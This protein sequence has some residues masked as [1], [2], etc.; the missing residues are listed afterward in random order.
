MG[1]RSETP[2]ANPAAIPARQ[3]VQPPATPEARSIGTQERFERSV[4]VTDDGPMIVDLFGSSFGPL[5]KEHWIVEQLT[6]IATLQRPIGAGGISPVCGLFLCNDGTPI[7]T[8]SDAQAGWSPFAREFPI[9]LADPA[10]NTAVL[11]AAG[12]YA[13]CMATLLGFRFEVP[14]NWR[15]RAIVVCNPG[16]PTPGPGAGSI[17]YIRAL[18]R[19]EKN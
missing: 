4:T 17:G 16:T 6:F 3:K 1:M 10:M 2:V 13:F 9:P 19:R 8:L 5:V 11:G 15:V 12:T 14:Q 18:A 7:E